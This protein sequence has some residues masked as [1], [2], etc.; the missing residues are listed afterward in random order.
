M[1]QGSKKFTLR[2]NDSDCSGYMAQVQGAL[3][4]GMTLAMSNWGTDWNTMKWL[5]QDT[6]CQGTCG[7]PTLNISNIEYVT[8]K[9]GPKPVPGKYTYGDACATPTDGECGDS[10]ADCVWSWPSNDPAAWA[11]KDADCRCKPSAVAN[12]L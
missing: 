1:T 4:A 10:C 2:A 12:M 8:G 11:S 3:E 7:S 9:P 5:D 6:G